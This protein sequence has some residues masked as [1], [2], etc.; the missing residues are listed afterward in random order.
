MYFETENLYHIYNRGNN[1]QRIFFNKENYLYFLRK[2][3]KGF[4]PYC[5]I[6]SYCLMPNHF[7]FLVFIRATTPTLQNLQSGGTTSFRVG[8]RATTLLDL[9][10]GGG[11][12]KEGLTTNPFSEAIRILLSSYTK[13]INIQE[14]R[15]GSLF[16]QNTKSKCLTDDNNAEYPFNCFNYIHQNPL[17]ASLVKK[18]EDWEFSSFKD[19]IGSRN[20][21]LVNQSLA[22]ELLD[23]PNDK[24]DFYEMSYKI[25][26]DDN[27]K[28]IF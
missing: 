14:N 26:D 1:K 18:M 17:E 27:I 15:T 23:L 28:G 4:L 8:N 3:R 20:G 9:G 24:K 16:Q 6:L 12:N 5:D 2:V 13:A 10:Q 21:T 7:H 11:T 22:K 19:Y 25:I